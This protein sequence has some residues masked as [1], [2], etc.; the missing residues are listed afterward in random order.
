VAITPAKNFLYALSVSLTALQGF[1]VSEPGLS[2]TPLADNPFASG[3]TETM[4][5]LV[6]HPNGRFL[7]VLRSPA[8]IEEEIVNQQ[9]GD[10]TSAVSFTGPAPAD[11]RVAVIDPTGSFLYATDVNGGKVFGY[12]VN[13]TDG[14]LSA[15]PGSPFPVAEASPPNMETIDSTGKFLYLSLLTRG[16][17]AFSIDSATGALKAVPGSPFPTSGTPAFLS[18]DPVA[19]FLYLCNSEGLVDGFSIEGATG[20]LTPVPGSPFLT[21]PTD[22]DISVDPLGRFVYV[23][24]EARSAV[25]GFALDSSSGSLTAI[26][27]APFAAVPQVQ[28]LY[29]VKLP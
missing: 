4:N 10:L 18:A 3:S 6:L 12:Q 16:I 28:N 24:N 9:T 19:N 23:S 5:S 13:Q 15:V 27:G 20:S 29:I 26:P 11:F 22:S 7:Y 21:A 2:L 25:F 1:S 17:V 14:S 8:T